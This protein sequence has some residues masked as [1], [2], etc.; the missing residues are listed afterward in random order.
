MLLIETQQKNRENGSALLGSAGRAKIF[1][2]TLTLYPPSLPSPPLPPPSASRCPVTFPGEAANPLRPCFTLSP[3]LIPLNPQLPPC[4]TH[5][6]PQPAPGFNN[7]PARLSLLLP[8]LEEQQDRPPLRGSSPD[9]STVTSRV[10]EQ[11]ER[12]ENPES[13][14]ERKGKERKEEA[15][16]RRNS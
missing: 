11:V 15:L 6:A 1:G 9:L 16:R 12:K 7:S 2:F 5:G 8:G 14:E 4:F 10:K 13:R 3:D